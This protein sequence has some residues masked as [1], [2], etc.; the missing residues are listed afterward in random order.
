[1]SKTIKN[2]EHSVATKE[3]N[4]LRLKMENIRLKLSSARLRLLM[5]KR[6]RT[7]DIREA[8]DASKILYDGCIN[9]ITKF[10]KYLQ[11]LDKKVRRAKKRMRAAANYQG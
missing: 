5:A 7:L 3:W 8:V 10:K 2:H 9:D 4:M 11:S 1:M 6:M